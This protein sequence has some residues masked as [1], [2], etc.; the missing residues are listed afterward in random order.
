MKKKKKKKME[1]NYMNVTR[2]SSSLT[3]CSTQPDFY[4]ET[5]VVTLH[6]YIFDFF[7]DPRIRHGLDKLV[8]G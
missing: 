3:S 8:V 5:T 2:F 6:C 4:A 1:I 7:A